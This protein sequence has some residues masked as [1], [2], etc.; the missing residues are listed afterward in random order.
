M[1]TPHIN[2]LILCTGNS[3]RSIL[4]EAIINH[5]GQ[6]RFCGYSAGSQPK[7]APHPL[8]LELL[9]HMKLPTQNLRSK[10]WDE[11]AAPDAPRMDFIFTVCDN[12]AGEVCP[13][14]PGHPAT[15]HWGLD[16]PAAATGTPDEQMQA[17]RTAFQILDARIAAFMLLPMETLSP[18]ELKRELARIGG[19]G[20]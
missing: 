18:D 2:I 20:P 7:S 9:R 12:A 17:F 14:W 16:D 4:A 8:A 11:F 6:G 13:V 5:R 1:T 19:L 10:S 3:A 15:A